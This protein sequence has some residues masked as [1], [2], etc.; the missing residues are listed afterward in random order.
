MQHGPRWHLELTIA[1][2]VHRLHDAAHLEIR[3]VLQLKGVE[4]S[5]GRHTSF[6]KY[7]HGGGRHPRPAQHLRGD[8]RS[9]H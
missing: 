9:M 4:D 3:L 1:W 6:S 8:R 2:I 7:P 5:T